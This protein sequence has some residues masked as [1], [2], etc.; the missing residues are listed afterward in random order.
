LN[1]VLH[2][3]L[4][5]KTYCRFPNSSFYRTSNQERHKFIKTKFDGIVSDKDG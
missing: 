2:K 1:V 4:A 3:F 5:K